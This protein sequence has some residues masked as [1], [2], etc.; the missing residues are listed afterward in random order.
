MRNGKRLYHFSFNRAKND[1]F[2][3]ASSMSKEMLEEYFEKVLKIHF[4]KFTI[5]NAK[6]FLNFTHKYFLRTFHTKN[7]SR[8]IKF[9]HYFISKS[10][11]FS[12]YF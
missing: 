8:E 11:Y 7:K 3:D 6:T 12:I 10:F 9:I 2:V 4:Q 1:F 5:S